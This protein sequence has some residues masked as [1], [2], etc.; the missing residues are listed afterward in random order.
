M[1]LK[2]YCI[3]FMEFGTTWMMEESSEDGLKMFCLTFLSMS[4]NS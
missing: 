3:H 1:T 2:S 4:K